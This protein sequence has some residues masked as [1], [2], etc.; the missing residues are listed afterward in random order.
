M[1]HIQDIAC[2]TH[3]AYTCI[4]KQLQLMG[5]NCQNLPLEPTPPDKIGICAWR[6]LVALG[7]ID[8]S[9]IKDLLIILHG[10]T[11]NINDLMHFTLHE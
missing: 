8:V 3:I 9:N 10:Y 4:N 5:F 2:Y 11:Y 1:S 6:C 7:K